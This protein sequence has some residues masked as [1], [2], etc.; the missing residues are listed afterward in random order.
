MFNQRR[1]MPYRIYFVNEIE[2][3]ASLRLIRG[4]SLKETR[5]VQV[6]PGLRTRNISVC[7]TISKNGVTKCH[8]QTTSYNAVTLLYHI[9]GLECGSSVIIMDN[10]P[11]HMST[12]IWQTIETRNHKFMLLPPYSPFLNPIENIFS[13]WKQYIRQ[14]R[15]NDSVDLFSLMENVENIISPRDCA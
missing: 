10:V 13:K 4:R 3:Q 5:V 6:V 8:A 1:W 2:F 12:R 11:F 15:P 14:S 9:D 7:C